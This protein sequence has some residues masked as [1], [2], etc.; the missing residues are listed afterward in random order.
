MMLEKY[1]SDQMYVVGLGFGFVEHTVNMNKTQRVF[2][3][4]V[5]KGGYSKGHLLLRATYF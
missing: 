3:N 1:R 4:S 2:K 5:L